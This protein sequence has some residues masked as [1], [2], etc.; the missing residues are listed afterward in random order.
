M[1]TAHVLVKNEENFIWYSVM[2]AIDLVNKV[3][4]WDT[5]SSDETNEI[6]KKLVEKYEE[7]ID[8]KEIGEV[9]KS[10]YSNV[11]QAMLD[12]T[13]SGWIFILDGDEIWWKNSIEKI[14]DFVNEK[15]DRYESIIVP[16]INLVGDVFHFQEE[17][18]GKY[19][20]GNRVGHYNLR[21]INKD[22]PGL[23]VGDDY[24]KEGFFDN[25]NR[26]IQDRNKDKVKFINVP[27]LHA[28]H[29]ERSS[30]DKDVM[31][32]NKKMKYE[33]GIDF[34]RDFYYPESFFLDRP[35]IVPNVWK[36]MDFNFRLRAYL[37]TPFRKLKRR[38]I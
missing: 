35:E 13:I 6:I 4:I 9:D 37:E 24:G 12:A 15:G 30:K 28:T 25:E 21:F 3:V 29:L 26:R 22:I 19:K 1:I 27:Y 23:Y 10:E 31:Q 16:T 2:S 34:D 32:R 17:K 20:F 38:V 5:G 7:K 33:I 18:A 36:N 8:Y 11:R 14:V